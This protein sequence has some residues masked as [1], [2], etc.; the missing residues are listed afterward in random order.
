MFK[1]PDIITNITKVIREKN[2]IT[3]QLAL[4]NG[5]PTADYSNMKV[6]DFFS[7]MKSHGLVDASNQP[8]QN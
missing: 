8:T 5:N 7:Q 4:L 6:V 2:G 1:T 3:Q